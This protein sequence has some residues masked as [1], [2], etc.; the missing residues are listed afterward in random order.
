MP[1]Q[2]LPSNDN[3]LDIVKPHDR[4]AFLTRA[5]AGAAVGGL[6]WVAPSILTIDAAAAA[7]CGTGTHTLNWG[8]VTAGTSPASVTSTGG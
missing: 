2:D 8:S 4:R 5:G 6:V 3:V 1:D 7:S